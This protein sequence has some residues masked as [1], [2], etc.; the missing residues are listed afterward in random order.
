VRSDVR[1]AI[2]Q[3]LELP[4]GWYVRTIMA[5]GHPTD[6][7]LLPKSPPGAARLPYDELVFEERLP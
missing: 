5:L 1:E 6:S 4:E 7:A 2:G 3:I